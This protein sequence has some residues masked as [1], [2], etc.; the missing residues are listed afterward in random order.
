MDMFYADYREGRINNKKVTFD[1]QTAIS[2][3][4]KH[5]MVTYVTDGN[6]KMLQCT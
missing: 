1:A 5:I 3:S 2:L 6:R 4:F